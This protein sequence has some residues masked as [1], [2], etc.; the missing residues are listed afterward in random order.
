[1]VMGELTQKTQL[2]VIGGGPGGYAAAFRAADLGMDVAMID[3]DSRPGGT[4]LFRGCIPSKAL[5]FATEL[6]YDARRAAAMGIDFCQPKVDLQRLRAWKEGVI[7]QLAGGLVNLT[8]RRGV[9]LVQARAVFEGYAKGAVNRFG[10]H[11]LRVRACHH[12]HRV[13]ANPHPRHRDATRGA[14]N[15]LHRR[16][17]VAGKSPKH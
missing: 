1:M 3:L 7:D 15:G 8:D 14:N 9:Q 5:L 17:G 11:P 16:P 4:C 10:D 12:R 2:L 6:M 13:T